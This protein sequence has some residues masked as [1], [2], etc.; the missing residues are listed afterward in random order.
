[1]PSSYVVIG[2]GR[3]VG[4]VIGERLVG[5]ILPV[6]GGRSAYGRDPGE[7]HRGEA[8]GGDPKAADLRRHGSVAG[9]G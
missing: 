4:R 3:G 2:G 9:V 7:T 1:V 8:L 6:D 5:A